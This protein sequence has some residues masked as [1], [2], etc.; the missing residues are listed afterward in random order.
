MSRRLITLWSYAV[1]YKDRDVLLLS[2]ED[3][4]FMSICNESVLQFNDKKTRKQ[5]VNYCIEIA[6]V[7]SRT[8]T[9]EFSL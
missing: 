6:I 3:C 2:D 1:C 5:I 8:Q 4:K 9:M 7:R